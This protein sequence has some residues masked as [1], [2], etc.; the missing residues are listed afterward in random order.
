MNTALFKPA[1]QT[2]SNKTSNA[3]HVFRRLCASCAEQ[4]WLINGYLMAAGKRHARA[5]YGF[6]FY[7]SA[8]NATPQPP[9]QNWVISQLILDGFWSYWAHFKAEKFRIT[10]RPDAAASPRSRSYPPRPTCASPSPSRAT[11][12]CPSPFL[13]TRDYYTGRLV[14]WSIK[15][16]TWDTFGYKKKFWRDNDSG[17]GVEDD[18]LD[19]LQAHHWGARRARLNVGNCS[20]GTRTDRTTP[21]ISRI[22]APQWFDIFRLFSK[23]LEKLAK[24]EP[25]KIEPKQWTDCWAPFSSYC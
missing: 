20:W 16:W 15:M 21:M 8:M 17:S 12:G 5:A 1:L 2:T 14:G 23:L 3:R 9:F 7:I 22:I 24:I 4:T 11:P 19:A 25:L 18:V 13:S 10:P 6:M